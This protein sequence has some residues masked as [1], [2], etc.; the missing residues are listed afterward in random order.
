MSMLRRVDKN[1]KRQPR[2]YLYFKDSITS[3]VDLESCRFIT[4]DGGVGVDIRVE[5]VC[6][7]VG[8]KQQPLEVSIYS[9]SLRGQTYGSFIICNGVIL[10]PD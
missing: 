7:R 1:S 5:E 2:F 4:D 3:V 6:K 8:S 9:G 10:I